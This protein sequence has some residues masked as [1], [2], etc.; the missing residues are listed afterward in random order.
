M[1][2]KEREERGREREKDGE[3][4]GVGMNEWTERFSYVSFLKKINK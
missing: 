1:M 2:I 4:E 3:R